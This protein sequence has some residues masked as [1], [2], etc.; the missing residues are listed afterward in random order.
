[1]ILEQKS[2]DFKEWKTAVLARDNGECVNCERRRHVTACFVVPPEV[3]GRMRTSNGVTIC[4]DCRLQAES[5]RVL[6]Q[7]IDDKTPINFLISKR[8]HESIETYAKGS[9]FGNIS[10]LVRHMILEFITSPDLYEDIGLF[11]DDGSDIKINGWVPGGHYEIFKRMCHERNISY[12]EAFK[13][14]LLVAVDSNVVK[15]VD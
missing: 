14:L 2:P 9:N 6:P 12:T 15:A 11:Q 5:S 1:M 4:R 8:L 3:G 10:S 13:A 7:R